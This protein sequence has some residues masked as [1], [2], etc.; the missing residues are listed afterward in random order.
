MK[1]R[2]RSLLG[3]VALV[4]AV[5]AASQW[6][7]GHHER[8]LGAEVAARAQPGDIRMLASET[9]AACRHARWW[10]NEHR[11]AFRE[12]TIERDAAC[13]AEFEASRAP[14][15]PL[16]VVRGKGLVGFSP[17]HLLQALAAA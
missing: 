15:T 4:L 7:A 10:F 17:E 11:V 9:C 3:L 14:G 13:R 1:D 2:S 12:C 5:S 6:W 16:I 8:Q